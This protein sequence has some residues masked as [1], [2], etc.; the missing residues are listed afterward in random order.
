MRARVKAVEN[1]EQAYF[2]CAAS[3]ALVG[4]QEGVKM[5]VVPSRRLE[6]LVRTC[7]VCGV[8]TSGLYYALAEV[9]GAFVD[10]R[11]ID[12]DEGTT[13]LEKEKVDAWGC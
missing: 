1:I 7:K 2:C 11:C 6:R 3:R 12:I 10:V 8:R 4:A 5:A 13:A 9:Q